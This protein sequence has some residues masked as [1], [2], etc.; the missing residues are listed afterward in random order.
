MQNNIVQ[1]SLLQSYM[2]KA[3]IN[4]QIGVNN[5]TNNDTA[6]INVAQKPDAFQKEGEEETKKGKIAKYAL[7][8]SMGIS[9]AAAIIA[10]FR[11]KG[12]VFKAVKQ[13]IS[14]VKN[15]IVDGGKKTGETI[16]NSKVSAENLTEFQKGAD[17]ISNAKDSIIRHVLMK[18]PGYEKFDA[19]ASGIYKKAALKTLNKTYSNAKNAVSLAD[20][21]VLE[22]AKK[23]DVDKTTLER[24]TELVQKR[25][26]GLS[27]F[28][29]NEAIQSRISKIDDS[30]Q[31]L[32]DD[33]WKTI[34]DIKDEGLMQGA[35]KLS[36]EALAE[37]RLKEAKRIQ[38]E[39]MLPYKNMGLSESE[40]QE[41]IELAGKILENSSVN[42]KTILKKA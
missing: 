27:D 8:A 40:A 2:Q 11:H 13:N 16:K 24:L 7:G 26:Q 38:E 10:S 21:A 31:R 19:W 14:K 9:V 28:T 15:A 22:A 42:N 29:S 18:I 20:D 41:Y 4:S 39:L 32:D 34:K 23:A 33:A 6:A 5:S 3:G 25:R 30:I 35:R 36:K 12:G 17:N 37:A 1:S